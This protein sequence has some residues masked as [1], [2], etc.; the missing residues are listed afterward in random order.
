MKLDIAMVHLL[1]SIIGSK[2]QDDVKP[3]PSQFL[4]AYH[5]LLHAKKGTGVRVELDNQ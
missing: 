4:Q 1:M 5:Q 3:L 2:P